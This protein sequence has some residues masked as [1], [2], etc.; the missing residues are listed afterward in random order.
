MLAQF[1]MGVSVFLY[2]VSTRTRGR[3]YMLAGA[4]ERIVQKQPSV[5]VRLF[6]LQ[7]ISSIDITRQNAKQ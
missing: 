5:S 4:S 2:K 1:Y 6:M 7:R 3:E